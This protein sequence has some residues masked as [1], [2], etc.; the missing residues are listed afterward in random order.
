MITINGKKMGKSYNNVIKLTEM[1]SG[2]H[3][4]LSQAFH[5][6]VIRFFILQSHYRSPLDFGSE[7]LVASEKALKR[8]WESYET[9]K[10]LPPSDS[11]AATD[12]ELDEK[13]MKMLNEFE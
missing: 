7:A 8:L 6:M 12:K 10:K 11:A 2:N 1:F 3:E 4:L 13:T 9:L 5:P